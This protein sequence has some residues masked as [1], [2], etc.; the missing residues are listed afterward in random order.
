MIDTKPSQFISETTKPE[1]K[2]T[3]LE[4]K[5]AKQLTSVVRVVS[6]NSIQLSN[7][8][9]PSKQL[10]S[11]IQIVSS[12][13]N[14]ISENKNPSAK[15]ILHAEIERDRNENL[16]ELTTILP[17]R[18]EVISSNKATESFVYL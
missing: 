16:R 15:S 8:N 5:S 3:K 10:S 17:S 12:H 11:K 4:N 2:P 18:V 1:I 9:T 14:V 13:V 6:S 7:A